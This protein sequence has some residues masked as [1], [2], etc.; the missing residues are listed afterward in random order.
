MSDAELPDRWGQWTDGGI[1][2]I[3]AL[4]LGTAAGILVVFNVLSR[5]E[6][7]RGV[8]QPRVVGLHPA[9]FRP[10]IEGTLVPPPAPPRGVLGFLTGPLLT[11]DE[12]ILHHCGLDAALYL[13][14]IKAMGK[15][16]LFVAIV[17]APVLV[18]VHLAG[19]AIRERIVAERRDAGS[20][21][22]YFSGFSDW[23]ALNVEDGSRLLWCVAGWTRGNFFFFFFFWL[24]MRAL[25]FFFFSFDPNSAH[26]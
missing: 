24:G 16:V 1:F 10:A 15:L 4:N 21:E 6:R 11:T 3:L 12:Q 5:L 13:V 20:A 26:R 18:P 25:F 14:F 7:N 9:Q 8:Y 19:D 17:T 23:T 22:I 2:T